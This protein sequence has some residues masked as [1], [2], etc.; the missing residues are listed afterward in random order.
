VSDLIRALNTKVSQLINENAGY[1]ARIESLEK[2][3]ASLRTKFEN[4]DHAN[5]TTDGH[6][7]H[8]KEEFDFLKTKF[9]SFMDAKAEKA[10][11]AA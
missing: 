10:E 2:D 3:N 9:D 5:K 4:L 11:K 1:K 7:I 8:L 6:Y